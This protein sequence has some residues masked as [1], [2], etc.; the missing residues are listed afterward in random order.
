MGGYRSQF[1]KFE[2]HE[3]ELKFW[4]TPLNKNIK[5]SKVATFENCGIFSNYYFSYLR[6]YKAILAGGN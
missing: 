2:K 3:S 6:D 4:K 1:N 5:P